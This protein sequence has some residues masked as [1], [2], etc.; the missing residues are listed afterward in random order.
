[1]TGQ[2]LVDKALIARQNA[3]A[4][5]S[6]FAVGAALLTS[7]G[8]VFTGCN[9]ENSSFGLTVCA[10]RVALFTAIAQGK[11]SFDMLAVVADT[12]D[13]CSPCGACRQVLAEFGGNIRVLLANRHGDFRETTVAELLPA[14]FSL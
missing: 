2:G 9:I 13:Y 12:E 6:K 8:E 5:Y 11:R 3:Y 10:E 7:D 1:M 14:A 4:P